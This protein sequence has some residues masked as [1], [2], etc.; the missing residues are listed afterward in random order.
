[1]DV[2][3]VDGVTFSTGPI[4]TSFYTLTYLPEPGSATLFA[5]AT[6][7]LLLLRRR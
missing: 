6:L 7:S 4:S 1:M 5:A 2:A 3:T